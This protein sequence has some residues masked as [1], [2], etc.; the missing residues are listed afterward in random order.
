MLGRFTEAVSRAL[1]E[2]LKRTTSG[3]GSRRCPSRTSVVTTKFW[4]T[5][6]TACHIDVLERSVG[7][8]SP[9]LEP[10]RHCEE[11]SDEA[12]SIRRKIASLRSQ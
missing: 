9:R 2:Q 7:L 8:A 11:R 10:W 3:A 1:R 12:I 6:D 4:V 5:T